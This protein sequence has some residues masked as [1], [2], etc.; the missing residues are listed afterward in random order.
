MKKTRLIFIFCIFVLC[1]TVLSSCSLFKPKPP[2]DTGDFVCTFDKDTLSATIVNYKGKGDEVVI[3]DTFGEYKVTHIGNMAFQEKYDVTSIK[4]PKYLVKIGNQA[5]AYCVGLESINLPDSLEELG[6]GAFNSCR[7][8]TEITIPEKVMAL[9]GAFD[10]CSSIETFD[11]SKNNKRYTVDKYGVLF[12]KETLVK[13]P[14]GSENGEYVIPDGIKTVGEYA[15]SGT[16]NL[17]KVIFSDSVENIKDSA[18]S[19]SSITEVDFNNN[20]KEIGDSAFSSSSLQTVKLPESLTTIGRQAFHFC[21]LTEVHIPSSVTK[22][23]DMAFWECAYIEKFTVSEDNDCFWADEYGVLY[24]STDLI[25]YPLGNKQ[26]EY[27]ILQD[28]EFIKKYAFQNCQYLEKVTIPESMFEIDDYAFAYCP[29]LK[30]VV[31]E[32]PEKLPIISKSAFY[33]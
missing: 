29:N 25:C 22:I 17:E 18:F 16:Q 28:T 2:K 1:V 11:V 4:L 15:F 7:G 21:P 5:F 14:S 12:E 31:Y 3:P 19:S 20:L 30:E 8:L 13:Y 26:T 10:G 23:E 9:N 24:D 33:K 32:N 6:Y 27:V